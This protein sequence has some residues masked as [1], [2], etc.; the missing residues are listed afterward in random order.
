MGDGERL[1]M[2]LRRADGMPLPGV[3]REPT[4]ITVI[5]EIRRRSRTKAV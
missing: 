3:D 1:P 4:K 5:D 2:L